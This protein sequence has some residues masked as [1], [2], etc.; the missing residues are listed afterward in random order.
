MGLIV[1]RKFQYAD[2]YEGGD[3]RSLKLTMDSQ[4]IYENVYDTAPLQY[5]DGVIHL[6]IPPH[7]S[8]TGA[9]RIGTSTVNATMLIT[10]EIIDA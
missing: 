6:V 3:A 7:T 1:L 8:F 10:G 9:F 4:V 5:T 2:S